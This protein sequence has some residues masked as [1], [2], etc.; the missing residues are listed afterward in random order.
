MGE[1]KLL[2]GCTAG[3][4]VA[5]H[6]REEEQGHYLVHVLLEKHAGDLSDAS[7]RIHRLQQERWFPVQSW[8]PQ[9]GT[10]LKESEQGCT[11]TRR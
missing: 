1:F 11:W 10:G 3:R 8:G 5:H 2:L 7:R 6:L 9:G 4:K